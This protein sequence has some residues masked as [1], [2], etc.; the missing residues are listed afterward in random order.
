MVH[1]A[2]KYSLLLILLY[3]TFSFSCFYIV[4]FYTNILAIATIGS[5]FG[6]PIMGYVFDRRKQRSEKSPK[7]G[8]IV[9]KLVDEIDIF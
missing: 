5:L 9:N 7:K 4:S 6:S 3:C 1:I 8:K 2:P